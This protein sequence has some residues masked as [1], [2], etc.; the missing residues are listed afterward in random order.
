MVPIH[1]PAGTEQLFCAIKRMSKALG[2][3]AATGYD[4]IEQLGALS[5]SGDVNLF[6]Q[7]IAWSADR[8]ITVNDDRLVTV[9]ERLHQNASPLAPDSAVNIRL[10]HDRQAIAA[11]FCARVHAL[12]AE[13]TG[14]LSARAGVKRVGLTG[15]LFSSPGLV[16]A[17]TKALGN[18]AVLAPVPE[19]PGRAIG[20][21]LEGDVARGELLQSGARTRCEQGSSSHW[22][23]AGSTISEPDWSRRERAFRECCRGEP[24][25]RGSGADGFR[26][27]SIRTRAFCAIPRTVTPRGVG[28]SSALH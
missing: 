2:L 5:A 24:W 6:D 28:V 7:A 10:Q 21:A 4:S 12:V 23:I 8:G 27:R 26:P 9:L 15:S 25:S 14:T 22:K 16:G 19:A 1:A 13:M 18:A 17:V 20:A 11:G 3:G